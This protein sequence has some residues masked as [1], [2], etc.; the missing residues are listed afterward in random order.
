M[1]KERQ[2]TQVDL[3]IFL[4]A[5]PAIEQQACHYL[6]FKFFKQYTQ[7]NIHRS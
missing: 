1:V 2:T 5:R 7:I 6:S 4:V 3:Q